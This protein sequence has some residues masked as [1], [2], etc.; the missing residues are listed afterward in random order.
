MLV[1]W[2]LAFFGSRKSKED[3]I[4][5]E[6]KGFLDSPTGLQL[7]AD[8]AKRI[9][10]C[11]EL[12][13]DPTYREG[14]VAFIDDRLGPKPADRRSIRENVNI[15]LPGHRRMV[16]PHWIILTMVELSMTEAEAYTLAAKTAIDFEFK[17]KLREKIQ[18]LKRDMGNPLRIN[19]KV[20]E[21]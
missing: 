9:K 6:L 19:I 10:L 20:T 5:P 15:T 3:N 16:N 8:C 18:I 14:L 2:L 11:P 13:K 21:V 1:T 12:I 4:D 17:G 7:A